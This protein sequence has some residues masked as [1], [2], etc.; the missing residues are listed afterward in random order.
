MSSSMRRRSG[1]MGFS[2]IGGSCLEGGVFDPSIL[3][4]ERPHRH[5]RSINM[6]SALNGTQPTTA[7]RSPAV[8]GS[9]SGKKRTLHPFPSVDLLREYLQARPISGH[10]QFSA[11]APTDVNVLLQRVL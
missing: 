4:T 7:P 2:L 5:L 11:R 3:K 6:V 9:F 8:A 10:G 1:L